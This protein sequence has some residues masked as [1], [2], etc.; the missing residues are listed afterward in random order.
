[1]RGTLALLSLPLLSLA[2]CGGGGS[3][4]SLGTVSPPAGNGG[5]FGDTPTPSGQ[6]PAQFLDVATETTFNALGS[7]QSIKIDKESGGILYQGNASTPGGPSGTITYDPRDGVFELVLSDSK[8]GLSR[9]IRFQ[10]PAHRTDSDNGARPIYEVP[11]WD[12][13]NYL[14]V[15][16]SSQGSF[17]RGEFFYQRPGT[18]TKYV[19][20]A[21]FVYRFED[22]NTDLTEHGAMVFGNP[23]SYLQVPIKG[24]G[25]Y[26]G[27]FMATMTNQDYDLGGALPIFQW[28]S[29]S[30]TVDVDFGNS[31]VDLNVS[32]VVGPAFKDDTA[33]GDLALNIPSG[34]TF[35]AA[36][37]ATLEGLNAGFAGEFSSAS[38]KTPQENISIDFTSVN[39]DTSAAG[40]SSIDG[41]F[42]GPNAAELGGNF[43]IVGGIPDQRVDIHG[44]FTGAAQ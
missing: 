2:A 22:A 31:T 1:M 42:Y 5:G 14:H 13:F 39:P 24:S 20:L 21:G 34:S 38:F 12:G 37:T 4:N 28:I 32:G 26:E 3:V 11:N 7:F 8:A 23:T 41:Q 17:D 25:H 40:A 16:N 43:R 19:T 9:N 36:G 35:T 30:S 33:V 6:E 44:A 27:D 18:T 10:D 29:G 15:D